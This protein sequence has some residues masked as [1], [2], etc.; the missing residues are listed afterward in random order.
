KEKEQK[1]LQTAQAVGEITGQMVS[2]VNTMGDIKGLEEAKKGAAPLKDNAT[3]KERAKWL[4]GL[5]ESDAYQKA[6]SDY[7]VG[8][9]NQM[10]VQAVSGVLQGLVNGNISQ[11]VAGA[12][13]PL[14]AQVIKAQTTDAGGNT[15]V[16]ANAMAHA[17][18]G[19]VAA[20]MSG[21]NAAAGAAGAFSG[22]L[23]TRFIA[24]ALYHAST[25][26]DIARLS[27]ADKEQLSLLG[28]IAA[29]AA[30]AVAGNSS[31]AATTGA[32]AGKNAV[33]NNSL[34]G[35][36]A[37]AAV[38]ESAEAMKAQ[39]RETLGEGSLSQL[40][41]GTINALADGGDSV[42]GSADYAADAAMALTACAIGDSYCTKAMSDLSGKNQTVA[43]SVSA[44][45]NGDTWEGIKTL[46]QKANQGDQLALEGMGGLMAGILIPGK[47]IPD[48]GAVIVSDSVAFSAKQLDKKFKHAIDFD[49][50]TTKKNP[51]TLKQYETAIKSHLDDAA[52]TENGTYGFVKDSKVFFNSN[53]NNAV[54]IDK[55]G[56]FITGFKVIPG[57]P[58]YD[59]YMK[60]GILR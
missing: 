40:V 8:S 23:A 34:S 2:I 22:E 18:W 15:N 58:Q 45:M 29:G 26:E 55:S 38:K 3:E 36:K 20:Q 53:T 5:R 12:A 17:V 46:A 7:G 59:N 1:R 49:I 54:V 32:L 56:E 19:A 47:K 13:N 51:E 4:A 27:Q 21:G 31:A 44:L 10:V 37:R 48:V 14:V 39:V 57:T 50:V 41:N 43:D 16:V 28:T 42:L 25:P 11:A 33:E 52:T 6:M 30:G 9:K 60:N 35:D 24:E